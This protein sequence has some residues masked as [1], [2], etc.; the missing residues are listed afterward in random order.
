LP[1]MGTV[2]V[3][4]SRYAENAQLYR[5]TEPRSLIAVGMAVATAVA[6]TAARNIP[7]RMAA[8]THRRSGPGCIT[9]SLPHRVAARRGA[10]AGDAERCG[11]S[12]L[13]AKSG[14]D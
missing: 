5:S 6:S 9:R 11:Q 8:V 2:V 7:S 3:D 13:T 12:R 14:R 4:V 1:N 10:E